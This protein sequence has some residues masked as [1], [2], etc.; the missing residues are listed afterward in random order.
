MYGKQANQIYIKEGGV[1]EASAVL[2]FN[3]KKKNVILFDKLVGEVRIWDKVLVT[4]KAV[5]NSEE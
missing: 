4:N 2:Q 1:G 5:S 3:K